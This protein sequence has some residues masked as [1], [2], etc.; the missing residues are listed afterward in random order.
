MGVS[1]YFSFNCYK[2]PFVSFERWGETK[3]I[4]N[5]SAILGYTHN[6]KWSLSFLSKRDSLDS[7]LSGSGTQ[8]STGQTAAHWGSS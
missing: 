1:H 3:G 6:Y 8:Q 5:E 2:I 7:I 4:F